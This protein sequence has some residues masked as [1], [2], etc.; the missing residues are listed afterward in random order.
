[1]GRPN[2]CTWEAEGVRRVV[3]E[4]FVRA[5]GIS[6]RAGG[7][8]NRDP[9]RMA[10]LQSLERVDLLRRQ[11]RFEPDPVPPEGGGG[12]GH[13]RGAGPEAAGR[14]HDLDTGSAP[15]DGS[16]RRPETHGDA[17]SIARDEGPQTL[18]HLPVVAGIPIPPEIDGRDG[19]RGGAVQDPEPCLVQSGPPVSTVEE[20]ARGYVLPGIAG[21]V[22]AVGLR[23]FELDPAVSL[24]FR[25]PAVPAV[26]A[27]VQ[28]VGHGR[29]TESGR[30]AG[31]GVPIRRV[32]PV[33]A[34][35][36]GQTE[37]GPIRMGAATDPL[38]GFEDGEV[39][40][41]GGEP[42]GGGQTGCPGSYDG[43]LGIEHDRN[44]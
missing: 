41:E 6:E 17:R 16:D 5:P 7:K 27:P 10:E 1:M 39:D 31:E 42:P 21:L 20:G 35:I 32:Q 2:G 18:P 34:Q 33:T 22:Q 43:D 14:A 44:S 4:Y 29:E 15:A 3:R 13:D 24:R 38:L 28:P 37:G 25:H 11:A 19:F 26:D 8:A 36:E 9:Q 30:D 23:P 12:D 40:P